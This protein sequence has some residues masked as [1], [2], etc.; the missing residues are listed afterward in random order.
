MTGRLVLLVVV[1]AG[2]WPAAAAGRR[3][4][5]YALVPGPVDG[6]GGP[7]L[8]GELEALGLRGA[9]GASPDLSFR[10]TGG[11]S[12][13]AQGQPPLVS[14]RG[15]MC[16]GVE[17]APGDAARGWSPLVPA[18]CDLPR[19]TF[20]TRDAAESAARSR[21]QPGHAA[22]FRASVARA[23]AGV[24]DRCPGPVEPH[25]VESPREFPAPP[26]A[27][28]GCA[29]S[30]RFWGG[31]GVLLLAGGA[32]VFILLGVGSND[33]GGTKDEGGGSGG[34][35]DQLPPRPFIFLSYSRQ[36][37]PS[38]E[39]LYRTLVARKL[40]VWW[41]KEELDPGDRW[42][43]EIKAGLAGCALF[44]PLL[45]AHS[46]GRSE[47]YFISEW[48]EALRR[49]DTVKNRAFVVPLVIDPQLTDDQIRSDEVAREFLG[50]A[51]AARA[52]GGRISEADL[53]QLAS[54]L[55]ESGR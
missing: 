41:D 11:A 44:V 39:A 17:W 27:Q 55:A 10:V 35:R 53:Q 47:G 34:R 23:L 48:R 20:G 33:G 31:A 8:A 43:E 37:R 46:L 49:R 15:R 1:L 3:C 18:L 4:Q 36:D 42:R 54:L 50:D 5:T 51:Q 32:L 45:S 16:V 26:G 21:W 14:Y 28:V 30:P 13:V 12:S 40:V 24:I 7:A 6:L 19:Q 29:A 25:P 9:Q 22:A 38:A 52:P 2:A